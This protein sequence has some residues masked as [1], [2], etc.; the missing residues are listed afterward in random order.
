MKKTILFMLLMLPATV[1]AAQETV[2]S[3]SQENVQIYTVPLPFTMATKLSIDE[4]AELQ[5]IKIS[6]LVVNIEGAVTAYSLDIS[7]HGLTWVPILF[8]EKWRPLIPL[9]KGL[10]PQEKKN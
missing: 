9:P 3:D 1:F 8:E 4:V 6:I 5:K 2:S 7:A 10:V